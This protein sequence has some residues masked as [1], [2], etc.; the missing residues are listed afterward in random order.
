MLEVRRDRIQF[1][2]NATREYGDFV[3]FRMGP[4]NLF[5][6]RHPEHFRHVLA[7]HSAKY[8][9]GLGLAEARA[10]LGEGLLTADGVV[11]Q[12]YR[13]LLEASFQ[14]GRLDSYSSQIHGVA[15]SWL[16]RVERMAHSGDVVVDVAHEM[17]LVTL[18]IV[19]LTQFGWDFGDECAATIAEDLHTLNDW[20]MRRMM[21]L[22][23]LPLWMNPAAFQALGR[24]R[25]IALEILARVQKSDCNGIGSALA[26][27]PGGPE[28]ARDQVLTFLLAG[29]ETTAR[30]LAWAV[31]LLGGEDAGPVE[32]LRAE[33]GRLGH[34]PALAELQQLEYTRMVFEETLRLY[35]SVW[36]LPRKAIAADCIDGFEIPK[37]ADV[38]LSVYSLHRHPKY[39]VDP[40]SFL[41]ERF[42]K[43]RA[44]NRPAGCYLPFGLGK[45]A[46]IGS[47]F[48]MLEGM[49]LL[50]MFAQRLRWRRVDAGAMPAEGTLS[51]QP[52]GG[53][54]I[55]IA[56]V[57]APMGA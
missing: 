39:W 30:A 16:A 23:P 31:G 49:M 4:K 25:T 8:V 45:R 3:A 32:R 21:S 55:R 48:G 1:V 28:A 42:A 56:P 33:A 24:L 52:R 27:E 43:D 53:L 46:C 13:K 57:G 11:W 10:F 38:L 14:G 12:Q 41:P 26:S 18:R 36:L 6:L 5:L 40:D 51:L 37:G 44:A 2:E 15:K 7:D 20:A 54:R 9:K 47:R 22:V 35:P 19:G 17:N 34:V 29:H 50:A